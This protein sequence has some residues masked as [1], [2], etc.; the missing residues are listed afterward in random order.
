MVTLLIMLNTKHDQNA[1]SSSGDIA[2]K[3]IFRGDL[4]I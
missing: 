3:P 2:V 4:E 1:S